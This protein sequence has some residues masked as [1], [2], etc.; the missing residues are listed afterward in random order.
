MKSCKVVYK[1]TGG[2][3]EREFERELD[4]LM[5]KYSMERWASGYARRTQMRDL[6]YEPKDADQN[7]NKR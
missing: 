6:A 5:D 4:A 1:R 3:R 7:N 2:K